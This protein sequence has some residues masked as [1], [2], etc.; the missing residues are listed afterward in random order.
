LQAR[1]V[2]V[3]DVLDALLSPRPFRGA[4]D[5]D[6][7][8]EYLRSERGSHFDPNCVDALF[9]NETTLRQIC[10]RYTKSRVRP[11]AN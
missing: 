3:A 10:E 5:L 11:D 1:I 4:W 8:L 6:R 9:R 7:A 2:A